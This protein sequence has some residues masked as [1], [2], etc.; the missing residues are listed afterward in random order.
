M[1]RQRLQEQLGKVKFAALAASFGVGVLARV[2]RR[3]GRLR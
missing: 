3:G 2:A 1:C